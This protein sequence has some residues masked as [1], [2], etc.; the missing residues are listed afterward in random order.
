VVIVCRP[1]TFL[2]LK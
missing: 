2:E 1:T